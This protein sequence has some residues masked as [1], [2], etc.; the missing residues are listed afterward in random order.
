MQKKIFTK[1]ILKKTKLSMEFLEHRMLAEE[2]AIQVQNEISKMIQG[3][4]AS[5]SKDFYGT[6]GHIS[7]PTG[8]IPLP[9]RG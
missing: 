9:D 5:R 6:P 4:K 3:V 2:R 7:K 8:K 1:A